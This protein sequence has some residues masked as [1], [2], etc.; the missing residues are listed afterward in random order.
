MRS[1]Y[2]FPA[3]TSV[4]AN[5]GAAEVYNVETQAPV[6]YAVSQRRMCRRILPIRILCLRKKQHVCT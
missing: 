1:G 3:L 5:V 4:H 2:G 6:P